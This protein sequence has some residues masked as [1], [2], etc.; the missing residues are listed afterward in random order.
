[1][2]DT[3]DSLNG[4]NFSFNARNISFGDQRSVLRVANVTGFWPATAFLIES[5]LALGAITRSCAA[6]HPGRRLRMVRAAIGATRASPIVAR[7]RRFQFAREVL[8]TNQRMCGLIYATYS[9]ARTVR[10]HNLRFLYWQCGPDETR[11]STELRC[12]W[13]VL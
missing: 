5:L 4:A 3:C 12:C 13:R 6:H 2:L 9:N 7:P 11:C 1:M 8:E 10:V